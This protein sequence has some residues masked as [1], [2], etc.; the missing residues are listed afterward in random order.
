MNVGVLCLDQILL[1]SPWCPF[2]FGNCLARKERYFLAHQAL[3]VIKLLSSSTQL[4]RFQL[5]IKLKCQKIMTFAFK[6]SD[7]AF[8]MLISV[9]C[10]KFAPKWSFSYFGDHFCYY[11]NGKSQMNTRLLHLGYCSNTLIGRN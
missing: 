11:S 6:L 4:S 2:R 7:V 8:S 9:K 3:E 1:C 5:L 10:L